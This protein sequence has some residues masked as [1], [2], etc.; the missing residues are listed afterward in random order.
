MSELIHQLREDPNPPLV[1]TCKE[2][3]IK[4]KDIMVLS[5]SST[6]KPRLLNEF[7]SSPIASHSSFQNTYACACHSFCW[8]GMTKDILL[9]VTECEVFQ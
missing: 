8:E 1:Y 7:H 5:P 2:N 6:L 3:I 9:F 4:Y